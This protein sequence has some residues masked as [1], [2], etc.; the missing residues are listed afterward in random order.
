MAIYNFTDTAATKI[1]L[2][3]TTAQAK[4][5]SRFITTHGGGET[6]YSTIRSLNEELRSMI[7]EAY[8]EIQRDAEFCLKYGK[9]DEPVEY[10]VDFISQEEAKANRDEL[11]EHKMEFELETANINAELEDEIPF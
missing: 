1:N 10:D 5:L 3:L 7:F 2:N 11:A 4:V 8:T 9:F 6:S